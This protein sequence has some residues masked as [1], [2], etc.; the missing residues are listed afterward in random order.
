MG[1]CRMAAVAAD[2][3]VKPNGE[4]YE[5]SDLFIADG[6]VLPTSLGVNPMLTIEAMAYMTSREVMTRLGEALSRQR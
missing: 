4:L 3:P 2:G 5:C 1:T 6:S